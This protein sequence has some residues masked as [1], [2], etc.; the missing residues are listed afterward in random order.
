M[1]WI[2][3]CGIIVLVLIRRHLQ[4]C[5]AIRLSN[6]IFGWSM[7]YSF[8]LRWWYKLGIDG[9]IIFLDDGFLAYCTESDNAGGL[10]PSIWLTGVLEKSQGKGIYT[11]MFQ[12]FKTIWKNNDYS[13]YRIATFPKKFPNMKRWIDKQKINY[14][15]KNEGSEKVTYF[16]GF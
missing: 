4:I 6:Q 7:K 10:I 5:K 2:I 9:D 3:F 8:S 14:E 1:F 15:R 11:K 13:E 12:E 16:I